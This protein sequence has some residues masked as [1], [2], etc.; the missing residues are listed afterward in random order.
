MFMQPERSFQTR[1]EGAEKG[2][3]YVVLPF[4]PVN[5][6]DCD[7]DTTSGARSMAWE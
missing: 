2:R 7:P 4:D 3:A 1:L 6:W 5:T